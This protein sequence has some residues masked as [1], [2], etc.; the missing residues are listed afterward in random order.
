MSAVRKGAL[1]SMVDNLEVPI[2]LITV[3]NLQEYNIH[4]DPIHNEIFKENLSGIHK[5]DYLRAYFMRHYGGGYHDIKYTS[6]S[7]QHQFNVFSDSNVWL[8]GTYE[9]GPNDIACDPETAKPLTC[10]AVRQTWD[11]LVSNGIYIMRPQT[12]IAI[13]WLSIINH[14]LDLYTS[15]LHKHPAPS[16]R[17]CQIQENGYPIRWAELHGEQFHPL[18][19]KY[20]DHVRKGLPRWDTIPYDTFL[21][22]GT[23]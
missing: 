8:Y 13:E 9:N 5:A 18:Q 15:D 11:K 14:R 4:S 10:E 19:I 12:P 22:K 1:K 2:K 6:H 23:N 16:S 21:T 17:C 3:N 20:L 7:W